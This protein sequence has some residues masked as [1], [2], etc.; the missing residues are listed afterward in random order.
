GRLRQQARRDDRAVEPTVADWARVAV[1]HR[2]TLSRPGLT[3]VCDVHGSGRDVLL[4]HAGG[5]RRW[6]WHPVMEHL[7]ACGLRCT[8][9]DQRGHGE[10]GG[11]LGASAAPFADD[12]RAMIA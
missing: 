6:V 5:E 10:T 9:Y 7:A 3:L 8:A 4:L 11:E 12:T 1:M 2:G